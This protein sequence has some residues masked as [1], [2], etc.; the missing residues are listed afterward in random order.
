VPLLV[1]CDPVTLNIDLDDAERKI[2]D[3]KAGR[4][5]LDPRLDVVG[6]LPVHYGGLMVDMDA[7]SDF[8]A[9]HGLWV[10]EDAAH[11]LPAAFRRSPSEPWRRCGENTAAV[12]CF[13]FYAN[14]TITT[15]EGGM[16]VT[17][18]P[19]LANRMRQMALHG[20]SQDAWGRYSGGSW[21]YRIVAPGYKYNMSDLAASI[22]LHQLRRAESM[23]RSRELVAYRYLEALRDVEPIELP[24]VPADRI[25]SWHLFVIRLRLEKLAIDRDAFIDQ[26]KARGVNCSVHWRP[27]HL[28]P[29]YAETFGWQPQHLPVASSVWPRLVSL[30]LFPDL[31]DEEVEHVV[32]VVHGLCEF[33][34]A[35]SA[36]RPAA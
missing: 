27:L 7:V 36:A 1:D 8:A 11:A 10:V 19:R 18:D 31:R 29:Y 4:T 26:L 34:A 12:T 25:S 24:P 3:L 21:D 17:N 6:I 20:L 23:R 33:H 14:K 13:S 22:G 16:A 30:P 35:G 2:A 15:G 28:H 32:G 9:R 5:P